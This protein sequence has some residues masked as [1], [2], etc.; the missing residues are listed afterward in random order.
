MLCQWRC[1]DMCQQ[2][3]ALLLI[4]TDALNA[5]LGHL[6]LQADTLS[7]GDPDYG[8]YDGVIDAAERRKKEAEQAYCAHAAHHGCGFP[9][10]LSITRGR[11]NLTCNP[12]NE[13]FVSSAVPVHTGGVRPSAPRRNL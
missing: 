2:K 12:G 7:S 10:H 9:L 13:D 5:L 4:Y 8:R 11:M 6:R 3:E 1:A